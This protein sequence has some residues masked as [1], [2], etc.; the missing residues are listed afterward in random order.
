MF[1]PFLL[2][3]GCN[4]KGVAAILKYAVGA[5]TPGMVGPQDRRNVGQNTMGPSDEF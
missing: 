3:P 4:E 5:N 2:P 1:F